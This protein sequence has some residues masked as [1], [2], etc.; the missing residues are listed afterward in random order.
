VCEKLNLKLK[1][2]GQ[3]VTKVEGEYIYFN[4]GK[5]KGE[6]VGVVDVKQRAELMSKAKCVFVQTQYIGPFEGVHVEAMLSGTPVITTDWG[7][8]TETFE[9]GK[10]GFRTRTFKETIDAVNK[11][12]ELNSQEIRDFAVSKYDLNNVKHKYDI[13]FNR[14]YDLWDKGWYQE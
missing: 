1:V 3:G 8:F 10:H 11:C 14:L 9:E 5:I 13:Y 2:A 6:Y 4:G 12:S 7:C